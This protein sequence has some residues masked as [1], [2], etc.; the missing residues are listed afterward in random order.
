MDLGDGLNGHA[1]I[2]HGGFVA[3]MLD[4]VTGVL[5]ILNMVKKIE[6]MKREDAQTQL[7]CFTACESRE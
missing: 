6:E 5:I 7:N 2:V 1:N 4:E 3:T